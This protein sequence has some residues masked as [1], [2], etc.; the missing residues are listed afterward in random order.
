MKTRYTLAG[1]LMLGATGF[2]QA[3]NR[4]ARLSAIYVNPAAKE[5]TEDLA[6]KRKIVIQAQ[7]NLDKVLAQTQS[8]PAAAADPVVTEAR[9][10]VEEAATEAKQATAKVLA[11]PGSPAAP[12][13]KVKELKDAVNLLKLQASKDAR[14]SGTAFLALTI[15]GILLAL[16]ASMTG[17]LKKA[18]IAGVLSLCAAAVGGIPKA[19]AVDQ[20]ADYYQTLSQSASSLALDLQ[21]DLV[22]TEDDYNEYLHRMQVLVT[23]SAPEAAKSR[24]A[25]E[26]M[27]SELQAVKLPHRD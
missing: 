7:Q 26:D 6:A 24:Q 23:R 16:G 20:R 25:A 14:S 1:M 18:V 21:F 10:K 11:Q 4:I 15:A 13:D 3:P 2:G 22:I 12:A 9:K 17:F 27:I 8:S 5:A 19:L